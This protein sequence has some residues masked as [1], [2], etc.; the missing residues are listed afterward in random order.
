LSSP[1]GAVPHSGDLHCGAERPELR[2]LGSFGR[3]APGAAAV[4]S[5][6]AAAGGA[7]LDGNS[8]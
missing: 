3:L 7:G 6:A 2:P 1:A 5:G 8:S 4:G